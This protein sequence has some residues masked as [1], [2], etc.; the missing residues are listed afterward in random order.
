MGLC[1]GP[2]TPRPQFGCIT[3]YGTSDRLRSG[4]CQP[5]R[6][7]GREPGMN[8]D[9]TAVRRHALP[10]YGDGLVHG[11]AAADVAATTVGARAVGKNSLRSAMP[12]MAAIAGMVLLAVIAG[13][14]DR[15]AVPVPTAQRLLGAKVAFDPGTGAVVAFGG[16]RRTGGQLV[17]SGAMWRW[18][19]DRWQPVSVTTAPSARTGTLMAA[20]PGGHGLLLYGGSNGPAATCSPA[21]PR[22]SPV[23]GARSLPL[24]TWSTPTPG[25]SPAE[26]GGVWLRMVRLR[27]GEC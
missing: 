26:C 15:P 3:A 2:C 16:E 24:Q 21:R 20:D 18:S 10:P 1:A 25:R 4:S 27:G 13:C 19:H 12:A 7:R 5:R 6:V 8:R 17:P 14:G 9:A 23:T 22:S 11:S